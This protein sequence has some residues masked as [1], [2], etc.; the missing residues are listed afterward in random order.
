MDSNEH[1]LKT[2]PHIIA[3][4]DLLGFKRII[5]ADKDN[6]MLNKI[7]VC[8]Q[9]CIKNLQ[10]VMQLSDIHDCKIKV[11]SDNIMI[12][13]PSSWNRRDDHHPVIA[14]NRIKTAVKFIQ[15]F[16]LDNDL[17]ISWCCNFWRTLHR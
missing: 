5:F 1:N 3:Y 14:L 12:A 9:D 4:L 6:S 2:E 16:F 15:R 7:H 8:M 13:I 10:E 17:Y 11:F